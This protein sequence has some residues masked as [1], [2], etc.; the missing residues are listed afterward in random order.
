MTQRQPESTSAFRDVDSEHGQSATHSSRSGS[1][2][3][4]RSLFDDVVEQSV[5]GVTAQSPAGISSFIDGTLPDADA[6]NF[7]FGNIREQVSQQGFAQWKLSAEQ[8]LVR[9]IAEIDHIVGQ[10]L[11]AVLHHERFQALES[12]WRGLHMVVLSAH[13]E[14]SRQVR[15]R[16]LNLPW[17]EVQR[18]F[19]RA[20]EFDNSQLFKKVYED[21]FGTP[22]GIPFSVLIGNYEIH[23]RPSKAH[24]HDDV[25]I[26]GHLAGI[27]GAA[28]CPFVCGA[29]PSMFGVDDFTE[30]Q[31]TQDLGR[32]FQLPEF[33]KWRSLRSEDE[34][35][36]LGVALPRILM[37]EPH[38][39]E[40]TEGFCFAEDVA[41]PNAKKY[42]WGNAAFAWAGVVIRSFAQTGWLAEIR[43]TERNR[44]GGGLVGNLPNIS[45]GTDRDGV[46]LRSSTD[47][48]VTDQQE[49]ELAKLGFLPLCQCHDTQYSAFYSSQ[50]IQKPATY[51]SAVATANANI[52]S[53]LQYMLCVSRFSHY[54][55]VIARD[56]VGSATEPEEMQTKLDSWIKNYVTPDDSARPEVK[57]RRP[58]RQAEVNV[59]RDP[60]KPGAFQCTFSLLPHY[61]LDDLSA[62][63]RLQTTFSKR[64]N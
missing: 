2:P 57:A 15:V 26:L 27:A 9:E 63:I 45:F 5:A 12:A 28:F 43:G 60:G 55:K 52:S 24:P 20:N 40:D 64:E 4:Q 49:S 29:S 8:R 37:R 16:V 19:E 23:P 41:G 56:I 42:L 22:G 38:K 54:L 11:N 58:L 34:A 50:S 7:W 62:S 47:L 46:A 13:A 17:R 21:E 14:R 1:Q 36:F 39:Q 6:I 18:D 59:N 51:D 48:I 44:D 25:S 3:E 33:V 30:L 61:Q 32:G 31:H 35:R 53:M 10:Q